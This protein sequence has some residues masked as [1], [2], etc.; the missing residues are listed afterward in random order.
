MP[1][2]LTIAAAEEFAAVSPQWKAFCHFVR[3]ECR[4]SPSQMVSVSAPDLMSGISQN[5]KGWEHGSPPSIIIIQDRGLLSKAW[6]WSP[7]AS[8]PPTSLAV[9]LDPPKTGGN[10]VSG[11]SPAIGRGRYGVRIV[12]W[13]GGS[14]NVA[15]GVWSTLRMGKPS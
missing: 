10:G 9:G 11:I 14:R 8:L 2:L 3:E 7:D 5:W 15:V 12:V 4:S 13:R 6:L 1:M